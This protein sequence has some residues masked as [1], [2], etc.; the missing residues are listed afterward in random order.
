MKKV[1]VIINK[2]SGISAK[3]RISRQ[4]DRWLD[5]SIFEYQL[6]FTHYKGH[7]IKLS[8]QA[9]A[10]K[11]DIVVAVGGDGSVNE[12]AQGLWHTNIIL[13]I[14]PTGSGNGLARSL[15]IPLLVPKAIRIINQL[16]IKE[17]DVGFINNHL[18]LSN[19]GVGFDAVVS[20][21]FVKSNRRGF[22][23]YLQSI[24]KALQQYHPCTYQFETE[25]KKEK[26]QAFMIN[27]AHSNQ[28][29]YNFKLSPAASPFDGLLDI[30]IIEHLTPWELPP[31]VISSFTEHQSKHIKSILSKDFTIYSNRTIKSIQTDGD[32]I[33]NNSREINIK[34]EPSALKII[35]PYITAE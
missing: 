5:E 30:S 1:L 4:I 9:A 6:A 17:M 22:L 14:I 13:G 26:G 24:P 25:G 31:I 2:K 20:S 34:I 10:D 29:G 18:F 16:H 19:A 8:R 27:V 15:K 7:A 11:V 12:I 3:R 32:T 28:M 33:S 21:L 35:T 23:G